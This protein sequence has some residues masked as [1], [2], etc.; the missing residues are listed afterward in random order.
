MVSISETLDRFAIVMERCLENEGFSSGS[1][2]KVREFWSEKLAK[3]GKSKEFQN[4]HKAASIE[5]KKIFLWKIH[6]IGH[7]IIIRYAP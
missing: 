1:E 3:T 2:K 7:S 5:C 6:K 4:F